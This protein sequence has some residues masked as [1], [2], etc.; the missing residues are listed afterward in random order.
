[1]WAESAEAARPQ[2]REG[3][4]PATA[5]PAAMLLHR[6]FSPFNGTAAAQP[7]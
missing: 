1:M 7:H 2:S 3:R 5:P 6:S 4:R